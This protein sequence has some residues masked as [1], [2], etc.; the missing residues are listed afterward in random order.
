MTPESYRLLSQIAK[1]LGLS[2]PQP[3]EPFGSIVWVQFLQR[4]ANATG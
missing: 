4:V 2:M 3:S 1:N